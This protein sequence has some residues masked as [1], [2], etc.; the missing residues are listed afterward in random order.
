MTYVVT[1]S[2]IRCM[3]MACVEAC[4]VDCIFLGENMVMIHPDECIDCG[5]CEVECP[6][7]AIVP[8]SDKRA[9]PWLERN[10]ILAHQ[11]PNV[12]RKRVPSLDADKWRGK[13]G[14]AALF[15]PKPGKV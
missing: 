13:P 11:W 3:Y 9:V 2:C 15:S 1:E 7:E 12:V 4:P 8:D 10:H 14:K 5:V 6:T